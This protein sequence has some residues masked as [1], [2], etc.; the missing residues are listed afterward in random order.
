MLTRQLLGTPGVAEVNSFGGESEAVP[1]S[2]GSQALAAHGRDHRRYCSSA[3][4]NNENF[5]RYFIDKRPNS[6]SISGA[7][8]LTSLDDIRKVVLKTPENAGI[9]AHDRRCGHRG[10]RRCA[11]LWCHERATAKA[12]WWA[13]A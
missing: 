4:S 3:E 7:G 13:A 1:S 10:L 5:R 9:A 2:G 11:A 8:L 12:K 6:Y